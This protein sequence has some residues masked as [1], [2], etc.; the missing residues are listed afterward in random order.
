MQLQKG[1][2]GILGWFALKVTGQNPTQ[3][4]DGVVPV[5]EVGDNYLATS[6]M[7]LIQD[8]S[9]L[10]LA[11]FSGSTFTC[12]A[13]KVWRLIN[14]SFTTNLNA[15]D[16]AVRSVVE[17]GILSPNSSPNP[18]QIAFNDQAGGIGVRGAVANLRPP[19]FLPSGWSVGLSIITS[20]ALTVAVPRIA[21]IFVQ[22]FDL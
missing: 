12:P 6:E 11:T 14:A 9:N 8:T 4:G 15:A 7:R 20:A 10:A 3:F 5:A 2:L 19:I 21:S 1:P 17:C 18:T 16:I 22:E 13:G